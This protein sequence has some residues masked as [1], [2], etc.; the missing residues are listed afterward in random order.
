MYHPTISAFQPIA[1]ASRL[2]DE[3][4]RGLLGYLGRQS[5]F[6]RQL[7][8]D[9]KI[10]L[11][12]IHGLADLARIPVTNKE[13]LQER[14]SD[15]FCVSRDKII[16]YTSTSGTLGSPVTIALTENDLERL[17]W[18]EYSSFLCADGRPEDI[19]QLMLTLDR[20]F[21]AGVAYY[22]GIRKMG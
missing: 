7:F 17:A 5:P 10:D 1:E 21:M 20:Q 13:D 3:K 14:N 9:H 22:S 11:K 8:S 19:Y 2:Q 15:F 4:L 16:E 12:D 6:Y 18:N